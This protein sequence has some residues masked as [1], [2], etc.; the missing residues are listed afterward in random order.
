MAT[1]DQDPALPWHVDRTDQRRLP[2]DRL[3][4]PIGDGEG[5]DVYIL[6]SGVNYRHEEFENRAK[7]AGKKT[8]T[9]LLHS[10]V[11]IL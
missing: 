6:D 5:V 11:Y 10:Y 8:V 7:Y 1:G 9:R 4:Q 2:L 3:Y